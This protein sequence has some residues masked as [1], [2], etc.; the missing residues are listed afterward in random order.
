MTTLLGLILALQVAEASLT[1]RI[2]DSS[3]SPLPSVR[4]L[5]AGSEGSV[6]GETDAQG[7]FVLKGLR[8]GASYHYFIRDDVHFQVQGDWNGEARLDRMMVEA[9]LLSG[10]V[11]DAN[12]EP[13]GDARLGFAHVSKGSGGGGGSPFKTGPDGRFLA[14]VPSRDTNRVLL[15]ANG[16]LALER[17]ISLEKDGAIVREMDLGTLRLERGRRA[18]GRVVDGATGLPLGGARLTYQESQD[19]AGDFHPRLDRE[20]V[21]SA[22]DGVF[23]FRAIPPDADLSLL[24]EKDGY[25]RRVLTLPR[26]ESDP[27]EVAMTVGGRVEV[28]VCGSP[29]E[30]SRSVVDVEVPGTP[31]PFFSRPLDADG[32]YVF[33]NVTP[34]RV[35][36]LRS[37]RAGDGVMTSGMASDSRSEVRVE[38]G[39]TSRARIACGVTPVAGIVFVD[40]KPAADVL[41][42]V[43]T[44]RVGRGV[45]ALTDAAGHFEVR[46]DV[47]GS[48][49]AWAV[50]P[51]L[52]SREPCAVPDAGRSDCVFE[53]RSPASKETR[54]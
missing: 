31:T 22:G 35:F 5:L 21:T 19:P 42:S 44:G 41:I 3:G 53:L 45:S 54:P 51:R 12:G 32:R 28:T 50:S 9:T 15:N 24:V 27:V 23:E 40:G 25:A 10:R 52:V 46:V 1:G 29:A 36:V 14:R 18:R 2:T 8:R 43:T 39:T 20:R 11:V 13:V 16:F 37:W 4:I 26:D 6:S 49:S 38:E 7:S 30:I 48:Y 34:G 47:A 33:E 17:E